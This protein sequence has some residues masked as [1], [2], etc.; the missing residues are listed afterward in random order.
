[1]KLKVNNY[2]EK[3]IF[4]LT[5]VRRESN[6]MKV[7]ARY[8]LSLFDVNIEMSHTF[9]DLLSSTACI[10]R[11]LSKISRISSKLL[12]SSTLFK[13]RG[14]VAKFVMMNSLV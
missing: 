14:T 4:A 10:T 9:I 3:H 8:L 7:T 11:E 1:M 12:I 6:L 13:N 5:S 2:R